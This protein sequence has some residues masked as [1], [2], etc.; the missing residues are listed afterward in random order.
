MN[1]DS[2]KFGFLA[3]ASLT[4][5]MLGVCV[6]AQGLD[7]TQVNHLPVNKIDDQTRVILIKGT[8]SRQ[9]LETMRQTFGAYSDAATKPEPIPA[10]LIVL[11]DS[12]GGDGIAAMEI[13]RILRRAKAH[14][15]VSGECSSACVFILASGVMRSAPTFTV[16]IHQGRITVSND[17]GVIKKEVDIQTDPKAKALFSRFEVMAQAYFAEMG[18]PNEL[19]Q[20]MQAHTMKGVHRLTAEEITLYG[21]NGFDEGYLTQRVDFYQNQG[22]RWTQLD[23]DELHRRTMKVASQCAPLETAPAAY[24]ECYKKVLMDMY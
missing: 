22:G 7:A 5:L 21:L 18:L 4:F 20:L 19:F 1:R 10:G 9:L 12:R 3:V 15:M 16:G 8:I 23:K 6:G 14:T 17:A 11:L 24:I 13:G 2:F